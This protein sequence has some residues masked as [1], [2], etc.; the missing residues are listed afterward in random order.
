MYQGNECNCIRCRLTRLHAKIVHNCLDQEGAIGP[1][2]DIVEDVAAAAIG[3]EPCAPLTDICRRLKK[4]SIGIEGVDAGIRVRGV[5]SELIAI[6]EQEDRSK[7][8]T[9]I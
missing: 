4:K 1:L 9:K 3:K 5:L 6:A 7:I 2:Q 8:H